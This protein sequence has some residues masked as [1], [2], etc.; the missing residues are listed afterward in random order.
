MKLYIYNIKKKKKKMEMEMKALN[1]TKTIKRRGKSILS[2][3]CIKKGVLFE[4]LFEVL[5]GTFGL[6]A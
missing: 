6:T 4:V 3:R 1:T 5:F 2:D